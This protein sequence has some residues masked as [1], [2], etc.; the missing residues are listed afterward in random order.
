MKHLGWIA[1]IAIGTAQASDF[2]ELA[3]PEFARSLLLPAA[4]RDEIACAMKWSGGAKR[5][6][7]A[8][9]IAEIDDRAAAGTG[10]HLVEESGPPVDEPVVELSL[11]PPE[12]DTAAA[13]QTEQEILPQRCL[14]IVSAFERG[15]MAAAAPLLAKRPE[16][17]I[18]LPSTGHCIAQLQHGMMSRDDKSISGDME[19]MRAKA[20]KSTA[21]TAQERSDLDRDYAAHA[22]ILAKAEAN[23]ST[24]PWLADIVCF[25]V[26]AELAQ[27]IGPPRGE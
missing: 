3:K 14:D 10:K 22:A 13:A 2:S 4:Q 1:F 26:I 8:P 12:V 24:D 20:L 9:L 25:P 6:A 7:Y 5:K 23:P 15:G 17:L 11:D 27:K 21:L 19:Q 16:S 18:A